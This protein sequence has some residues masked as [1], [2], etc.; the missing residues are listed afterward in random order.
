MAHVGP[1]LAQA[2]RTLATAASNEERSLIA[3]SLGGDQMSERLPIVAKIPTDAPA[4]GE[5]WY[6]YK[7]RMSAQLE[8]LIDLLADVMEADPEP[9]VAANAVRALVTSEMVERLAGIERV[10]L[11]ELDPLVQIAFMD[12]AVVDVDLSTYRTNHAGATGAGVR[13]AVLDSGVDLRHPFL[14]VTA[15]ATTCGES[16]DVPGSHGT[17]CA[18]TIASRDVQ[19]PGI[20][21]GVDLLNIKVLM[22]DGR[23]THTGIV[24]GIDRALDL[25][26]HVLSMS[27][28][29]NHLPTWSANGH[30]WSCPTGQ[31]PLCT[32]VDNASRLDSRMVV[33]AAGNEHA[34]ADA[35]RQNGFG[36]TFDTELG[37]PGQARE[38]FTVG[39]ISKATFL[40]A[41]F[42]SR[43]PSADG[44]A[45]PD[46][47]AP[48]VNITSTV[49]VPR[50]GAGQPIANPPRSV[51]FGRKSGT[52][53]ATPIVAGAAALAIE[54]RLGAGQSWTPV[55]I[56]NDL[57]NAAAGLGLPANVAGVGRLLLTTI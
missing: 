4:A 8:P 17:H 56:K 14:V 30:G 53:M 19:F 12:D 42:S 7:E 11:L 47:C 44:R 40:M 32:A 1:L 22:S 36:Q 45:K 41:S 43:G 25:D 15:S 21:P 29:F 18:G 16:V 54:Q 39:A 27:L 3:A 35:L 20:A 34:R 50:D 10:D 38:A 57:R 13:V 5:P 6:E 28:G 37:C 51:L 26:A 48:G 2:V 24:Q 52:S 55:D 9:L 33:V 31:C 49:P 23:G 46:I